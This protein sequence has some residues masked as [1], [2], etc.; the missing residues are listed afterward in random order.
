MDVTRQKRDCR[1]H[2]GEKFSKENR[3]ANALLH[4]LVKSKLLKLYSIQVA[5]SIVFFLRVECITKKSFA[6]YIME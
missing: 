3:L 1:S 2:F 4:L 6:Y 5:S